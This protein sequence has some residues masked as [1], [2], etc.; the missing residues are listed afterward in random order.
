MPRSRRALIGGRFRYEAMSLSWLLVTL[1]ENK[2]GNLLLELL[3]VNVPSVAGS[4]FNSIAQR[5]V[6]YFGIWTAQ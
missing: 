5:D 3:K 1:W 4:R 6:H 2:H